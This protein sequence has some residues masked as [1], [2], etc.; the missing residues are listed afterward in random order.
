MYQKPVYPP[1]LF[2]SGKPPRNL[3]EKIEGAKQA[4]DMLYGQGTFTPPF[5]LTADQMSA[6]LAER[7]AWA[8]KTGTLRKDD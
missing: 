6:E 5:G 8:H 4:L 1:N 2:P 7:V 3:T